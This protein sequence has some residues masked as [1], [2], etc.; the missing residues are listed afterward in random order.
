MRCAVDPVFPRRGHGRP[1]RWPR[2]RSG[3]PAQSRGAVAGGGASSISSNQA[4]E[5]RDLVAPPGNRLEALRGDRRGLY[6]I[7]VNQRFRICFVCDVGGPAEVEVVD[8]H[9]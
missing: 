8:Y 9:R 7:R 6:S 3:D 4:H 5:L 2:H 1:L